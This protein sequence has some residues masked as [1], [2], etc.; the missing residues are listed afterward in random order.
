LGAQVPVLAFWPNETYSSYFLRN[1][2]FNKSD[3]ILLEGKY[4]PFS[5]QF[6]TEFFEG[7]EIKTVKSGEYTLYR[8]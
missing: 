7:K 2:N 3:L 4:N 5:E 6:K 8:L 1:K